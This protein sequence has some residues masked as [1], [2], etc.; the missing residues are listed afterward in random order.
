V[1]IW[2][3]GVRVEGVRPVEI[4]HPGE[5]DEMAQL[6]RYMLIMYQPDGGAPPSVDMGRVMR[7]IGE[8]RSELQSRGAWVFSGALHDST[9]ATVVRRDTGGGVFTTDGPFLE[10]KEHIGGASIIDVPDLDEALKSASRLVE[11]TGLPIEVRPMREL[12]TG[13]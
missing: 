12:P 9:T 6:S 11:I 4:R 1:S 3:V 7:E 2:P 8:W 10:G 5:G 13:S